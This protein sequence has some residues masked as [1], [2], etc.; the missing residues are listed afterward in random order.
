MAAKRVRV[1]TKPSDGRNV[2]LNTLKNEDDNPN[3]RR[4]VLLRDTPLTPPPLHEL[5]VVF[6]GWVTTSHNL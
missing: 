1:R 5:A 4:G 6:K 2:F 3:Y